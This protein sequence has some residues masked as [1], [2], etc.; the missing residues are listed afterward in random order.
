MNKLKNNEKAENQA[1][2]MQ[3]AILPQALRIGNLT[4]NSKKELYIVSWINY[5]IENKLFPVE[6]TEKWIE[7]LGFQWS[8]QHQGYVIEGFDYVIDFYP[9]YPKIN[10]SLS[11]LNKFHR[12]G[13]KLVTV[14]FVH[15]LQNIHFV[16]TQRDLAVA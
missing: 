3:S 4:Y 11:F 12:R 7:K 6:I 13:D 5:N 9:T 2:V 16:L 14:K 15:E 10:G 8:I 1:D